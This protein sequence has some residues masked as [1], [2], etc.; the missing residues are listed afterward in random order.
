MTVER[1]EET[2]KWVSQKHAGVTSGSGRVDSVKDWE[3]DMRVALRDE[4]PLGRYV[5]V[6][7]KTQESRASVQ[8]AWKGETEIVGEDDN[9]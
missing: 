2:A 7:N 5:K 9:D 3:R 8:K 1:N 4:S 6:P